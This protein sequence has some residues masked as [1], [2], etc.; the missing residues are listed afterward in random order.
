[1]HRYRAFGLEF[2]SCL[3]LPELLPGD[4]GGQADVVVEFGAVG[5]ELPNATV[6][7]VR[8]QSAPGRLW[9][10]VDGVARYL[11]SDG[12]RITI[13][14]EGGTSEE[15][16]RAF[17]LTV[18]VGALLHQRGDLVLHASAVRVR[19]RA[20]AFLGRSGVGKSTLAAALHAR[21]HAVM[22][23]DLAVVR[24]RGDG[25]LL[26]HPAFPRARLWLDSLNKLSISAQDLPRLRHKLEKRVLSIDAGFPV[27]PAPAMKLYV[28][29]SWNRPEFDLKAVTGPAKFELIKSNTYRFGFLPDP[30]AKVG[31]FR[32]AVELAARVPLM[33]VA[34]P[35]ADFLLDELVAR[36]EADVLA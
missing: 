23:D 32:M 27:E 5:T 8:Y 7:G 30:E 9:L 17:L 22:A 13:E 19:G 31:H 24:R 18:V 15:D 33:R 21:G 26:L 1:M 36:I 11:V 12:E 3:R 34:R 29:K 2:G 20:V 14:P 25:E 4:K 6:R 35:Q 28:L 10:R 16:V